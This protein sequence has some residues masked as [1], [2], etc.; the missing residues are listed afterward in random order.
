ML[1]SCF[2][3]PETLAMKRVVSVSLINST[4]KP[5]SRH[6]LMTIGIPLSLPEYLNAGIFSIVLST[7][8]LR[9]I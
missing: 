2:A 3:R 6:N 8:G 7:T 4:C 9:S 5:A 1:R